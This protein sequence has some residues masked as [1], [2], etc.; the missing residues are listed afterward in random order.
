MKVWKDRDRRQVVNVS[1]TEEGVTLVELLVVVAIFSVIM[2]G[3]YSTYL[4]QAKHSTREHRIAESEMELEIIKDFL[5]RD[6]SMAGYGFADVY[7]DAPTND[8]SCLSGR[9]CPLDPPFCIPV[10]ITAVDGIPD[11]LTLMGTALGTLSRGSQGW[12][13][14]RTSSPSFK[15]WGDAR[16]D[17]ENGDRVVYLEP[18]TRSLITT[19]DQ[20]RFNYPDSPTLDRG[21]ILYGLHTADISRPYYTVEYRLGGG[22]SDMPLMCAGPKT[23]EN[24]VRSLL[25]AETSN[26]EYVRPILDCVRDLQ[27]AFGLDT[28]D[29]G[30]IDC[31]DNGGA[32]AAAYDNYTLKRRLK[33][34]KIFLLVQLGR[35]DPDKDVYDKNSAVLRVGDASLTACDGGTVGRDLT[36]T[37]AQRRYRWKV[38]SLSVAPRN[39]R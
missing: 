13:Y 39:L 36:L 29:D 18:N 4:A 24:A 21:T 3:V 32:F 23:G 6:I 20:W 15:R 38:L 7:C 33:Q 10:A 2:A 28:T 5:E 16:E 11:T 12:T 22:P 19:A 26:G 30:V 14:I 9:K 35:R 1:P 31:W 34:V 25:R 8:D 27:V 17:I 37:D